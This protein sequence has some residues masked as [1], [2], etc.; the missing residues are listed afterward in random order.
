[1]I[2]LNILANLHMPL[3]GHPYTETELVQIKRQEAVDA[4]RRYREDEEKTA[5][6]DAK[7][8]STVS[9]CRSSLSSGKR[10]IR[11]PK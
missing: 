11:I 7:G 3:P 1:M 2:L 10:Q 5:I 8:G 6:G 9:L 4:E